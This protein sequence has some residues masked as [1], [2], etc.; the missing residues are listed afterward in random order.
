MVGIN[1]KVK[2]L[3]WWIW[4]K[5]KNGLEKWS[6]LKTRCWV[7]VEVRGSRFEGSS[8]SGS[9]WGKFSRVRGVVLGLGLALC[10][11]DASA[12]A[13]TSVRAQHHSWWFR[14]RIFPTEASHSRQIHPCIQNRPYFFHLTTCTSVYRLFLYIFI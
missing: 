5:V 4:Y 14:A 9:Y 12:A 1:K 2:N 6:G 8:G 11:C 7:M 13:E 10:R 3:F